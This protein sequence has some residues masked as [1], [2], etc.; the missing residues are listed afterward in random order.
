VI[1]KHEA[2]HGELEQN[3][4]MRRHDADSWRILGRKNKYMKSD[5]SEHVFHSFVLGMNNVIQWGSDAAFAH[6]TGL[7][8]AIYHHTLFYRLRWKWNGEGGNTLEL[9]LE[10]IDLEYTRSREGDSCC[11]D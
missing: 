2:R 7:I 5:A 9:S 8:H 6:C 10:W 3:S 1:G 11:T 4:T